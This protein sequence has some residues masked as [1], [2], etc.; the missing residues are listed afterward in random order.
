MEHQFHRVA[1]GRLGFTLVELLVVVAII[2]LLLTMLLPSLDRAKELARAAMCGM[3]LKGLGTTFQMYAA[4]ND[5]AIPRYMYGDPSSGKLTS[6]EWHKFYRPYYAPG[7][8][9]RRDETGQP[10]EKT[11]DHPYVVA[12]QLDVFDCP[13]TK[14]PVWYSGG[15]AGTREKNFDYGIAANMRG[16]VNMRSGRRSRISSHTLTDYEADQELLLESYEKNP[17]WSTGYGRLSLRV[18]FY[19][20]YPRGVGVHHLGKVN[21]L[22]VG[23]HVK[24]LDWRKELD[25]DRTDGN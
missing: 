12:D 23:G 14:E 7:P 15:Y 5:D 17:W 6:D 11:Y 25:D 10:I 21:S 9:F 24:R 3:N 16:E 8:I 18:E 19:V 13:T 2:A 1:G 4:D 20:G 22:H